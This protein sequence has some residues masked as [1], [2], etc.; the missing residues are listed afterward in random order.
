MKIESV[1]R[2]FSTDLRHSGRHMNAIAI[3]RCFVAENTPLVACRR[4]A[5]GRTRTLMVFE[6][7]AEG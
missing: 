4:V 1:S 2:P 3:G 6:N 5:S 7:P